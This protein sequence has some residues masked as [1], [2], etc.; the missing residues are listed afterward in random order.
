[1]AVFWV[2]E[3]IPLPITSFLPIMIFP[4]AD[5]MDTRTTC[6]CYMNDTILMFY[7]SMVLAS[8]VEQS[9]LHKR[10]A[11]YAITLIGYSHYRLLLAMS[12]TTMFV[13]MWITNTAATTMMVPIIFAL[14]QVFEDLGLLS[15]FEKDVNGDL[16]ASDITTC[17]FCAASFS[18]TIGGIGTLVGS[19][20][21]LVFK[22]LYERGYPSAPDY[23]SFPK[24]SAFSVPYMLV[25][26]AGLYFTMIVMFF[27]FLRPK[28]ET[29]KRIKIP[30]VGMQAAKNAVD[31]NL[32][33]IG[34]ITF[35]EIMVIILFGGAMLMFFS[36]SPQI[37]YG[38]GDAITD[39]YKLKDYKYVRDSAAAVLVC[40]L[41]LVLPST[42]DFFK[43]FTAKV[44]ELP[45]KR[46]PSVLNW[47]LMNEIMPYSFMFL[48]GGGFALSTAAKE[49]YSDLNGQIGKL[50]KT[51]NIFPN[52]FII[53][54]V[55]IFTVFVTNFASN[56][57][58]CT[59]VTPIVMQLAKETNIHPLWYNVASGVSS[60]F[61][62]CL[63][64]GTP[65]NLI[66]QSCANIPTVKMMKIG[67]CPSVVTILITW[68]SM[69]YWAPVIWPDL[70]S[71]S[72]EDKY[73]T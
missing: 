68:A 24:Y 9:G 19:A 44:D 4:L 14:L 73:I 50:L 37:F 40:F 43:N 8:A 69:Y 47:T 11:L 28:S 17:Y 13:S 34:K 70:I 45:N 60:S 54:L 49:E 51:L 64:V 59:V 56:V 23:L 32:K 39:Y 7:G 6:L 31:K 58:V 1:M 21:N 66:I 71:E 53:L 16:V 25:L 22:G 5:V 36:R 63:P 18:A 72:L 20:T 65:G 29:A 30:E 12:L 3:C 48:L 41:M 2:T 67:I 55:I 62:F 38:W 33:E 15:T 35:W 10:L 26:E 27:G 61:C 42:L 52:Y 57:A 46:I